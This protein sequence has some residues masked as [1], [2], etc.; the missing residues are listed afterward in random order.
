MSKDRY[1]PK[2]Q[3]DIKTVPFETAEEAW[4]WFIQAQEARNEGARFTAGMSLIPRPCEPADILK[5]VERLYR[6][7][8]LVMDHLLVLRHYGKRQMPPDARRIKEAR[9]Y[10][11]WHEAL[12]RLESVFEK[13]GIVASKF[14][15]VEPSVCWARNAVIYE[16]GLNA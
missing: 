14:F 6:N 3:P 4:L 1:T 9:A 10:T 12:E 5:C 13:K 15:S 7:R 16:G 2:N 11:L 8:R